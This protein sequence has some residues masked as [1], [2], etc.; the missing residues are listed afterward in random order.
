VKQL[1]KKTLIDGIIS[2]RL[3]EIMELAKDEL[4]KKEILGDVPSGVIL[5]GG[6]AETVSALETAR[7]ILQLPA[8]VGKPTQLRGLIDEIETPM[9]STV[10]GLLI[11]GKKQ[12]V[13]EIS[14]GF[15]L[16]EL[17]S[18]FNFKSMFSSV[19]K[20]IKSIWP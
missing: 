16:S 12:G 13:T 19:K 4:Q 17:S 6:G 2:P 1:S 20:L 10:A 5:T 9:Y 14:S 15:N 8:R 3:R 7:K 11:Y 18:N